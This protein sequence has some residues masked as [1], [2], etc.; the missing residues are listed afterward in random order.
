MFTVALI[1]A[2]GSG[3]SSVSRHLERTL[4]FPTK[5]VYMGVNLEA[6][7]LVLPSTRLL[8]EWKRARGRRPD[9]S[10]PRSL[11]VP[12]ATGLTGRAGY[13]LKRVLRVSNLMAEEWFR[14]IIVRGYVRRVLV[15]L[16]DR[17]FYYDYHAHDVTAKGLPWINRLHGWMLEKLY[18]KPDLTLCLDA[19]A[20]VLWKR[21]TEGSTEEI[22][23]RREEYLQL[24]GVVDDFFLVDA[25][26]SEARVGAE[27]ARIITDFLLTRRSEL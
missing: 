8:L 15:V 10:R 23:K 26:Q 27:A 19:P 21:K 5:Y 7:N 16:L 18:P 2:D 3:K 25:T 22:A 4:P 6:S 1:G 9:L 13:A 11:T 14:Q 12:P 20:E 17:H 24:N